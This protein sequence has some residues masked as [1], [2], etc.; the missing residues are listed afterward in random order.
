VTAEN[1]TTLNR[2]LLSLSSAHPELS[3]RIGRV[4]PAEDIH[5]ITS[6]TGLPVAALY[7]DGRSIPFHSRIDP[8]REGSRF[9]RMYPGQGFFVFLGLGCGYHIR[10]FLART[11]V[12]NILIIEKNLSTFKA[13][14]SRIDLR[15]LILD[16][17]VDFIID[18]ERDSIQEYLLSRYLPVLNGDLHSVI[19]RS[20][21][22]S[23]ETYFTM[24][25][26]TIRSVI[27]IL[28]DD[29]TVQSNF[30]RRWFIN[31]LSNLEPAQKST[32][33]FKPVSRVLI[34]AAGPSL[35]DQMDEIEDRRRNAFLLATDTSLPAL[36]ERSI[37][38]DA[39]ISIDCQQITYNHFLNGYPEEIPLILDISS[40]SIM[41][42][43]TERMFFISTNHPFSQYVSRHFRQFPLID[44]S[45]GNVSHAAVSLA[46]N[47]MADEIYLYGADFSY[48]EGKAYAR[49]TY[50]YRYFHCRADRFQDIES[51]LFSFLLRNSSIEKESSAGLFRYFTKPLTSYKE[52]LETLA[53]ELKAVLIPA[54][55]KGLPINVDRRSVPI[56]PDATFKKV[57]SAGPPRFEWRS[58]LRSYRDNLIDLPFAGESIAQYFSSL[59]SNQKGLW[60]TL[61]PAAAAFRNE[62]EDEVIR[63]GLLLEKVKN[64]SIETLDHYLQ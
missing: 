1:R 58:F 42:R 25:A 32:L 26:E 6:K 33:T 30:G 17:K 10:P 37:Y 47:L 53:R 34:T 8:E 50:I 48:P 21:V 39:V 60:L 44:T 9:P 49:G 56:R 18:E 28:A 24:I 15:D 36:I 63:S 11:E 41:T 61:F 46:E 51:H 5:F 38:P 54:G 4:D 12:N 59:D 55:G 52:R 35:E 23:E 62:M 57:L 29:Y 45:G 7:R 27:N 19:L 64:W 2:N 13:V 31:T 43:F 16:P 3:I 22:N 20:R 40:P 14:L